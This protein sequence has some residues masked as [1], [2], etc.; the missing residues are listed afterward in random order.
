LIGELP[1]VQHPYPRHGERALE[2]HARGLGV[3][4]RDGQARLAQARQ[5]GIV[6]VTGEVDERRQ[7]GGRI[8]ALTGGI[9]GLGG[10]ASQLDIVRFRLQLDQ[11]RADLV[12]T[13]DRTIDFVVVMTPGPHADFEAVCAQVC[14]AFRAEGS[15]RRAR[16]SEMLAGHV[17]GAPVFAKRLLRPDPVWEW[18]FAREVAMYRELDAHPPGVRVPRFVAADHRVLVIERL[19]GE[20]LAIRRR[21]FVHMSQP[22][23]ARI[24]A[25][26][27]A[28][29]RWAGRIAD[30]PPPPRVRSQLRSRLLEDP[31]AP[32]EWIRAG[33][34]VSV[35]RGAI[36]NDRAERLDDAIVAHCP[37]AF[38]HGDLLLRNMIRVDSQT[39]GLVDW[40][41]A[42]PHVHDWD[43]ALLWT[44]LAL[45]SRPHL[46]AMIEAGPRTTAFRA[47][48]VFALLRELRFEQAY[49][50]GRPD[51]LVQ[52]EGEIASL[53]D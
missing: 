46:D 53:I 14:P 36:S 18:Y 21:P 43:L 23:V 26:R 7:H 32:V 42:G 22:D 19:P 9:E 24:V 11:Q 12:G 34:R 44:Q 10:A 13:H 37:V 35:R 1:E 30:R 51:R 5:A 2:L 17:D 41:C 47:L 39:I 31:T 49:S 6:V 28:L 50:S 20:P 15:P 33:L 27:A 48:C 4:G 40:E 3:G 38:G 25:L 29:A 8:V 16:K 52:I 45:E